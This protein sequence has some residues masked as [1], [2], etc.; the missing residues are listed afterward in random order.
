MAVRWNDETKRWEYIDEPAQDSGESSMDSG[1]SRGWQMSEDGKFS[2]GI[3]WE[4]ERKSFK[5]EEQRNRYQD[6]LKE[7]AAIEE[8]GIRLGQ[9]SSKR[10]IGVPEFREEERRRSEGNIFEKGYQAAKDVARN[11]VQGAQNIYEGTKPLE[12][13]EEEDQLQA[14]GKSNTSNIKEEFK[15]KWIEDSLGA[16]KMLGEVDNEIIRISRLLVEGASQGNIKDQA[17]RTASLQELQGVKDI[18][19]E[20]LGQQDVPRDIIA[21][22]TRQVTD[23]KGNFSVDKTKTMLPFGGGIIDVAETL[24]VQEVINKEAKGDTLTPK[25]QILLWKAQAQVLQQRIDYGAGNDIGAAIAWMPTFMT[26]FALSGGVADDIQRKILKDTVKTGVESSLIRKS[27][28]WL[29]KTTVA[30]TGR[31]LTARAPRMVA[32]T[33]EYTLPHYDLIAGENGDLL[34]N[35]VAPGDDLLKAL[36]KG[37]GT[38]FVES[39]TERVGAVI[40]EPA[41]FINKAILSKFVSKAASSGLKTVTLEA[42][43]DLTLNGLQKLLKRV[44]IDGVIGEVFEEELAELANS[45]IEEREY[46][47]PFETLEGTERFFKTSMAVGPLPLLATLSQESARVL[48]SSKNR[49]KIQLDPIHIKATMPPAIDLKPLQNLKPGDVVTDIVEGVGKNSNFN[50]E[51]FLGT[52]EQEIKAQDETI[53]RSSNKYN[54]AMEYITQHVPQSQQTLKLYELRQSID[55]KDPLGESVANIIDKY[56]LK[57]VDIEQLKKLAPTVDKITQNMDQYEPLVGIANESQNFQE[58]QEKVEEEVEG[59]MELPADLVGSGET[60]FNAQDYDKFED[61]SD[62]QGETFYHG[63]T[64]PDLTELKVSLGT[65]QKYGE[66]QIP[67]IYLTTNQDTANYYSR[68]NGVQ[69][70]SP[71]EAKIS[72][73]LLEL[74]NLD[75]LKKYIDISDFSASSK[76]KIPQMVMDLGYVGIRLAKGGEMDE[77]IV[78]DEAAVKTQSQLKEIFEEAKNSKFREQKT[79]LPISAMREF[80]DFIDYTKGVWTPKGREGEY[81]GTIRE[82]AESYEI[83]ADMNNGRLANRFAK[84]LDQNEYGKKIRKG[85]KNTGRMNSDRITKSAKYR[86]EDNAAIS[87]LVQAAEIDYKETEKDYFVR[88]YNDEYTKE[89]LETAWTK[90]YGD[91]PARLKAGNNKYRETDTEFVARERFDIPSLEKISS[92]G[93]DRDVYNLG[94]DAVLKIAKTARG[95]AQNAI[96]ADYYASNAG[97]IP[98]TLEIGKNYVVVQKVG[99]PD[100][101]TKAMLKEMN[102]KVGF[103]NKRDYDKIQQVVGI[104]EKYGYPGEE[105]LNFNPLWGDL[106]AIRNWGSLDGKPIHVDGGSLSEGFIDDYRDVKNLDDPDFREAYNQSKSI[107]KKYGDT[108]KVTKYREVMDE[109]FE[110]GITQAEMMDIIEFNR[111]IFKDGKIAITESILTPDGAKA[112]GKYVN[113]WIDLAENQTDIV[114]TYY[115]EA[116]HKAIDLFLP[117]ERKK[118]IFDYARD[119]YGLIGLAAEEKIAE[120]FIAFAKG[121]D[122]GLT[123][124]IKQFFADLLSIFKGLSANSNEIRKFYTDL[125]DGR[126]QKTSPLINI[127]EDL[128]NALKEV[129]RLRNIEAPSIIDSVA[130]G[131]IP[132]S[133]TDLAKEAVTKFNNE[134]DFVEAYDYLF[135]QK[136]TNYF[137]GTAS[138]FYNLAVN[139]QTN[140]SNQENAVSENNQPIETTQTGYAKEALWKAA[141]T[142]KDFLSTQLTKE[143]GEIIDVINENIDIEA[144]TAYTENAVNKLTELQNAERGYR[145]AVREEASMDLSYKGVPSSFP[146]WFPLRLKKEIIEFLDKLP[147]EPSDWVPEKNPF[148]KG[149][150]AHKAFLDFLREVQTPQ[151]YRQLAIDRLEMDTEWVSDIESYIGSTLPEFEAKVRA[152]LDQRERELNAP[153]IAAKPGTQLMLDSQAQAIKNVAAEVGELTKAITSPQRYDAEFN[154]VA[155]GFTGKIEDST[156]FTRVREKFDEYHRLDPE[157]ERMNIK[158]DTARALAFLEFN[159]PVALEIALGK[160]TNLPPGITRANISLAVAEKARADG[161]AEL[162]SLVYSQLSKRATRQGQE[163]VVLRGRYNDDSLKNLIDQV[164]DRKIEFLE[165][166]SGYLKN[167]SR[168][169]LS[170]GE[171]KELTTPQEKFQSR[172]KKEVKEVKKKLSKEMIKISSAQEIIDMLTC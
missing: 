144:D 127:T 141:T 46:K 74:N 98:S 29:I 36:A 150:N 96:E 50:V 42:G 106:M 57:G 124:R 101:N 108:D 136:P 75:E 63:S 25:E 37:F 163:I 71:V 23:N 5:E 69:V 39:F 49:L 159:Y 15:S 91:R 134:A 152:A 34:L 44:G 51:E 123:E 103:L 157:Y 9:E 77:T 16:E 35:Q 38:T 3:D 81:E 139:Q 131:V 110:G 72:G 95:L 32:A 147:T 100:A 169:V 90:V 76:E 40:D 70:F 19:T 13:T 171:A 85:F 31:T 128:F 162:A 148:R 30:E 84:L 158:E 111:K 8:E 43:E 130:E 113:G 119:K 116:V 153:R 82:L 62:A 1:S 54:A 66:S 156:Y 125:I 68:V 73:K 161:D 48:N 94:D 88:F 65:D 115:H 149:T 155:Q 167:I 41:K 2:S 132:D 142:Q 135:D 24:M 20:Y 151:E 114:G 93:S 97:L 53:Q 64:V 59:G 83:N 18:L 47:A 87:R 33:A 45:A 52:F 89:Q 26:E 28:N 104:M 86:V 6:R 112:L 79:E 121:Q 137:T 160:K 12:T 55:M 146:K 170:R 60:K 129:S 61:F 21:G 11:V 154:P 78:F 105:L 22:I 140:E 164:Q 58:F 117:E 172:V 4:S 17:V 102:D 166:K 99:K 165:G 27:A 143:E 145:W 133:L 138:E 10:K 56:Y 67:G 80:A 118:A 14:E 126:L 168:F 120:D 109:Q 122:I 7:S 92:G 107:K